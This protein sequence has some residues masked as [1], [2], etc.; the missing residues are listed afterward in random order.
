MKSVTSRNFL[1][2]SSIDYPLTEIK[3]VEK[4]DTLF[5]FIATLQQLNV[6]NRVKKAET[7]THKK[8]NGESFKISTEVNSIL[9]NFPC[10]VHVTTGIKTCR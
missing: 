10:V 4:V 2:V 7:M 8:Q 3:V 1:D 9:L 5:L 6:D